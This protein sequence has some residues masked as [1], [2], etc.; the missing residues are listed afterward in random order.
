MGNYIL[1][2]GSS[3][4]LTVSGLTAGSQVDLSFTFIALD[5]WDGSGSPYGPDNFSVTINAATYYT[6]YFQ[7]LENSLAIP[8][9]SGVPIYENSSNMSYVAGS[10]GMYAGY[11]AYPDA[12]YT[13]T[14]TGLTVAADGTLTIV[15]TGSG[16]QWQGSDAVDESV[17]LDN[18]LVSTSAVPEPGTWLPLF[19]GLAAMAFFR[20][21]K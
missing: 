4:T 7:N 13:F 15:F 11:S 9:A 19:S 14:F 16:T 1:R 10:Y 5:S 8:L 17:G 6:G 20:R 2:T 21:R 18:I 3:T 12:A